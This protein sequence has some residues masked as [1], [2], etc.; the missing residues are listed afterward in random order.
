MTIRQQNR[1]R[2]FYKEV[3]IVPIEGGYGIAL[4]GT[5]LKTPSSAVLSN[6]SL[7]LIEAITLEWKSQNEEIDFNNM[8]LFRLLASSIDRVAPNRGEVNTLTLKFGTTDLLCYR[9]KEPE[10]LKNRQDKAWQPLIEWAEET[11]GVRFYISDSLTPI[12]Q[13]SETLNAM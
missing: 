10:E 7:R 6:N 2:K 13:P 8:P 3:S 5:T 12:K 11:L 9:A 1:T 4:D